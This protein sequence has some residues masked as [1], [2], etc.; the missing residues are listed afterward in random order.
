MLECAA[1]TMQDH[2]H[3]RVLPSPVL[4]SQQEQLSEQTLRRVPKDVLNAGNWALPDY[5]FC[6]DVFSE[7]I[8][9]KEHYMSHKS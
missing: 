8:D 2:H 9:S 4:Q 1:S 5:G 7:R 3:V 6:L